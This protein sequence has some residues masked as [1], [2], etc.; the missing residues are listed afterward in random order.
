MKYQEY[1]KSPQWQSLR[2]QALHYAHG[3]C[4]KCGCRDELHVHHRKYPKGFHND[5]ISNVIVLCRIC[6]AERHGKSSG[7]TWVHIGVVVRE[8]M[9]KIQAGKGV[10]YE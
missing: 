5:C 10:R 2:K 4:Q 9:A 8:I 3:A 7:K 6:H 1:L